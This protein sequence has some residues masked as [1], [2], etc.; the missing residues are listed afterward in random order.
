[1]KS[2]F[3]LKFLNQLKN[4]KTG[5]ALSGGSV[6]GAAHVGILR[7]LEES[8]VNIDYISGTSIGA[9]VAVLYAFGKNVREMEEIAK[10]I[11]WIDISG[12]SLSQLGLLS[13]KKLGELII[14]SI[15]DVDLDQ[16][17]I[18]IGIVTTD[19]TS[20]KPEILRHGNA[21]KAVMAST[22]IPGVFIPVEI[23]AKLLVDGG[24]V[25]NIP[26]TPLN[27]MGAEYIIGVNLNAY[28]QENKPG[29]I[30]EVLLN[31]FD[32]MLLH[33]TKLQAQSADLLI[34]PDLSRFNLIDTNQVP[35]LIE[36]GYKQAIKILKEHRP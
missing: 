35:D 15:G 19:I 27:A 6:L 10:E 4:K 33:A 5:L 20:G 11:K 14:D 29:N 17:D 16:A 25:E 22:A 21:A 1:M 26:L 12:L 13:N 23:D 9:F 32:H 36:Q 24:V 18:P 7:A 31:T 34:E 28:Q 30:V 2:L 8:D 3:P